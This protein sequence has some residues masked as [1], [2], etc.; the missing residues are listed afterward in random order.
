MNF[1]GGRQVEGEAACTFKVFRHISLI[2][3]PPIPPIQHPYR[4]GSDFKKTRTLD[5]SPHPNTWN[6]GAIVELE[7]WVLRHS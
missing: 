6:T 1:G 3:S 5:I 2:R 4:L 7:C